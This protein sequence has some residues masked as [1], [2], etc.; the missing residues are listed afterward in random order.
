[1]GKSTQTAKQ[2]RPQTGWLPGFEPDD[3]VASIQSIKF[4]P[5]TVALASACIVNAMLPVR[6]DVVQEVLSNIQIVASQSEETTE[7]GAPLTTNPTTTPVV[8]LE[9]T[10]PVRSDWPTFDPSRYTPQSVV[11]KKIELNLA[12]ISR[13][14]EIKADPTRQVTDEDRHQMLSYSGWGGAAR[15]F[16]DLPNSSLHTQ[17]TMLR[18]MVSEH[19]F[20]QARASVTSAYYT[21]TVVI[22][23]IWKMIQH[24]GFSGGRIIEPAAGTGLFIANMPKE[25]AMK[26][27]ITCIEP[28]P[29]S[30][31]ILE[32]VFSGLGVHVH[33]STIEK[34]AIPHGFYDLAIS[35]VPFGQHKSLET[36]KV[37]YA[38]WS[39][40]NYFFGKA[41][42]LVR[43]GGLVAMITSSYTMDSLSRSHREWI[44]AHAEFL[45]AFRLPTCA[46]KESA[47]TEVITDILLF[48][49]RAVAQFSENATTKWISLG[50]APVE[51]MKPGLQLTERIQGQYGSKEFT[52]R[53]DINKWYCLHPQ[54]VL[55]KLEFKKVQYKTL[56]VPVFSDGREAFDERVMEWADQL[57]QNVY[58]DAVVVEDFEPSLLMP[59]VDASCDLKPGAYIVNGK[60]RI[61]IG[62][63][64]LT[65]IDVDD[66]FKGKARD[67][68]VG[69]VSL[70]EV[71]RKLIAAQINPDGDADFKRY[72]QE[73]NIKYD[74]FV[75]VFGN[76][77]DTA[78][79]R[80]FRGDPDCPLLLSL[81]RFDEDA[82]V[83]KKADIFSKRTA[84]RTQFPTHVDNVKDAMLI[85]L[86]Q[87]GRINIKDM[88]MRMQV[89]KLAV[90][91]K[92]SEDELAYLDPLDQAWKIT[93]EYLSG[94]IRNKL[95]LAG[96]S[97]SIYSRNVVALTAALPKPLGP[98]EVEVRLG[99]PWVPQRLI[100]QFVT[101]LVNAKV[102]DLTVSYETSSAT[103]SVR[104]QGSNSPEYI[105]TRVLNTTT[106]GTSNRC[107]VVL[108]EAAL[109][110]VPPKITHTVKGSSVLDRPATLAARE[111]YEMI[112]EEF[113]AWAYRVDARRDEMLEIYN[114]QFNQ[115][116]ER[117]Y[118][119]SHMTF[120]GMSLV[121]QPYKSQVDAIW[122]IVSGGNTLLA[123]VVGAGKSFIMIASAMEM[124]R[125]GKANK[126]CIVVPNHLL[127][128]FTAECVR[129]FPSANILMATRDDFRGEKRHEFVA[130]IATSN[131]DAV[132]MTLST[133][134]LL[135]VSPARAKKFQD[136]ILSE[137]RSARD[138]AADV[139]ARATVR[140]CESMIKA[141]EAKLER[142]ICTEG[143]DDLVYFDELGIDCLYIDEAHA[144]KNLMRISKMPTV[145]GLSSASSNRAFDAWMKT[146]I[147]MEDRGGEEQGV[148]FAT[149]TS[150]SNSMAEM[151]VMQKFLQPKTLKAH[152]LYEFD[153]WA[154][155]FGEIVQ[156]MELSPD[157]SGY[158]LHSRF[159][160]FVNVPDLMSI[161]RQV[162]DI[163][164]KEMLSLPTPAIRGGKPT[165]AESCASSEL[166]DYT[167]TLVKRAEDIKSRLVKPDEDNMLKVT[168]SGRKAALDMRLIDGSLPFD[169]NGKVAKALENLLRIYKETNEHRGTQLVFCDLSTPSTTGFSIY[170]DLRMRLVDS[171]IPDNEIAFIHDYETD[172]AKAKL[173]KKVRAGHI[174]ILM[175]STMKMGVGTNVQRRLKAIHQLDSPWRPSDVM[176]RDGRAER[177][178]NM[179]DEI[180]LIRY[181][182]SKS[183]DA[184]IWSLLE[185][186]MRFI[187][188]VMTSAGSLRTVE[189]LSM[190]A[191]S[192]S[193]IKAIA[194]GNPKV[195]EK[196]TIDAEIMRLSMMR[197][198]WEQE[199]WQVANRLQTNQSVMKVLNKFM[200]AVAEVSATI[201]LALSQGTVS[202]DGVTPSSKLSST[203]ASL[204][205]VIG[206]CV[207]KVSRDLPEGATQSAGRIAGLDIVVSRDHGLA[208]EFRTPLDAGL[209]W[210]INRSGVDIRNELAI[211]T[212]LLDTVKNMALE[213]TR[214]QRRMETIKFDNESI[215]AVIGLP[216]AHAGKLAELIQKQ[217][218]IE[219]EL[220]MNRSEIGVEALAEASIE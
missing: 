21:D 161:F 148:I 80:V 213:H 1:M 167:A 98:G 156:G 147:I 70:R 102:D 171:G 104:P 74:T 116:V 199:R 126:P 95:L 166:L 32:T 14:L 191:L 193:E 192:Y 202:F 81:E 61:C 43:S 208:L 38:E 122:R 170:Q 165:V 105:G 206:E 172:A 12:A 162:A 49:K 200:P 139:K 185:N 125:I 29:L 2:A 66:A 73:L 113:K 3:Y 89:S 13:M 31:S 110:N 129:F 188:Q 117:Q 24:L 177:A 190:G 197:R 209:S 83:Y 107:A 45:G 60:G 138:G 183:F 10:Q 100:E 164:T 90:T 69:M 23:S 36:K 158:R 135:Q 150:L 153:A 204:E 151:H 6:R 92:L 159:S 141:L 174:R 59:T 16:E 42:D 5:T 34:A 108:V 35:N 25:I 127:Y 176:Q 44:N 17:Q 179:W 123:H 84:G 50:E 30:A 146:S 9:E 4:I 77:T 64:R 187:D 18:S 195:L 143:K 22:K 97:G 85:S 93:S 88:A 54:A 52:L 157:G 86:A 119:G 71:A 78:N 28:D 133:F 87:Y 189:D 20:T 63:D 169:P 103:W 194:S 33:N 201:E 57:P 68:L 75:R 56:I 106:W 216:F 134:E 181:I 53:R 72:Q 58:T 26:S 210:S 48:K 112:K 142:L 182:S 91:Q 65:W 163:R 109:N 215:Q 130:R 76:V 120:P 101:E 7:S 111:K 114:E 131:L 168:N 136:E 40:H 82:E 152:G 198:N 184:F 124:K 212:L 218:D 186:K 11:A 160:R 132:V 46:F 145:A 128:D 19:E 39:L 51:L 118:D 99:A 79:V 62:Q 96:S 217:V 67:R 94:H 196:A 55:G 149:A 137:V 180:E 214:R 173:F 8:T 178:G 154:S 207:N 37:G 155:T 115:I 27:E 211:G 121:I 175:G 219:Y 15:L 144:L 220:D 203:Q 41:I 205:E 47:G 140:Q